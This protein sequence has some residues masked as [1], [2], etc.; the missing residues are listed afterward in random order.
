MVVTETGPEAVRIAVLDEEGKLILSEF[1]RPKGRVVDY[2]TA[3]TGLTERSFA[4]V[5][6]TIE[7]ILP[8]F[9]QT[10]HG[11]IIV[12]HDLVNDLS[13]LRVV[14]QEFIDTVSLYPDRRGLPFK[15]KLKALALSLLK[16]PIQYGFHDPAEDALVVLKLVKK[17]IEGGCGLIEFVDGKNETP[18]GL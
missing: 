17:H 2:L 16:L 5:A 13:V 6:K 18:F 1:F 12:G 14:H 7:D 4:E 15:T 11:T 3:I 10:I 9:L 8:Q